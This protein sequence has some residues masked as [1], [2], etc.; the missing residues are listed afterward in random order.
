MASHLPTPDRP[1]DVDSSSE[2]TPLS[3]WGVGGL[4]VV[5]VE[6]VANLLGTSRDDVEQLVRSGV[7]PATRLPVSPSTTRIQVSD[8]HNFLNRCKNLAAGPPPPED[9]KRGAAPGRTLTVRARLVD[10]E[11]RTS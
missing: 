9:V 3:P 7:L 1:N 4:R 11:R 6:E 10:L 5:R 2:P 8:L